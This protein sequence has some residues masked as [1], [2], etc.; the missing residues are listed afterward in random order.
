MLLKIRYKMKFEPYNFFDQILT[1]N[2]QERL[3]IRNE[4]LAVHATV[5]APLPHTTTIRSYSLPGEPSSVSACQIYIF[6]CLEALEE[7]LLPFVTTF[8]TCGGGK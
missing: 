4:I 5:P 1:M 3:Q 2:C 8:D 6:C 7:L